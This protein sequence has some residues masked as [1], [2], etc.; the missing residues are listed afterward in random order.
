MNCVWRQQEE[1]HI[2][3]VYNSHFYL[4]ML[5]CRRYKTQANLLLLLIHVI[6]ILMS[7]QIIFWNELIMGTLCLLTRDNHL[8]PG[9]C[10]ELYEHLG[11]HHYF[12][13][14]ASQ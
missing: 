2:F 5:H 10:W 3:T 4:K 13:K 11:F 8:D 12:Q 7:S 6:N 1:K 14:A 9:R